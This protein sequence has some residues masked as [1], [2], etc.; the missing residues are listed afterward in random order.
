[1]M[2]WTGKWP[3][4]VLSL[5]LPVLIV[6]LISVLLYPEIPFTTAVL[7]GV[8]LSLLVAI[9]LRLIQSAK[10]LGT[11]FVIAMVIVAVFV[12]LLTAV[13]SKLLL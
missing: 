6:P 13:L 2:L 3:L 7:G 1:M 12:G 4:I 11:R 5:I 8:I 10:A 9:G